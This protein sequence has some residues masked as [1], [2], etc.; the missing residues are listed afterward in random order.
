MGKTFYAKLAMGNMKK[1][2][3]LYTP[4]LLTGVCMVILFYNIAALALNMGLGSAILNLIMGLGAVVVGVFATVFLYYTNSFLMKRRQ[5][6]FGLF[7]ML[8]MEKRHLRKVISF[9][10]LYTAMISITAGLILGILTNKLMF[11]LL[12]RLLRFEVKMGFEVSL[13]AIAGTIV[14]FCGIFAL[15]LMSNVVKVSRA[16]P[17]ELLKGNQTGE[18][19]PK[20]RWVLTLVGVVTLGAG[21]A[22]ALIVKEPLDAILLFFVAVLLVITGTYCLFTAGNVAFFKALRKNKSYYYKTRH[23]ISVSGMIYRMKRNAVGLGNICI[24]SAAV[25]LMISTTVSLYIGIEDAVASTFPRDVWVGYHDSDDA[26]IRNKIRNEVQDV[27]DKRALTAVD[28]MDYNAYKAMS[29]EP[30][31][32]ISKPYFVTLSDYNKLSGKS[33]T[34]S[35]GEIILCGAGRDLLFEQLSLHGQDFIVKSTADA[36]KLFWAERSDGKSAYYVVVSDVSVIKKLIG[37]SEWICAWNYAFNLDAS[38]DDSIKIYDEINAR[39]YGIGSAQ[40]ASAF[41]NREAFFEFAGGLLFLGIFLGTMFIISMALVIYYKQISEGY[42]DKERFSIMQKVGLERTEVRGTIRSQVLMVFFL[43]LVTAIIHI[44]VAFPMITKLLAVLNLKNIPLFAVCTA[45]T[46]VLFSVIY[47]MVYA[48]T[49]REYY[50][51]VR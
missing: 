28:V 27:L 20:T 7:N 50:R 14:L 41:L 3:K 46:M 9:E 35:G 49:S 39:L 40:T 36:S 24:L 42:E 15:V 51:I 17:I 30:E 8:G 13:I 18:R 47:G 31:D 44:T 43:P 19:E 1:N 5:K 4:F 16:N 2:G 6:E 32:T 37:E 21:Y 11:L 38:G 23:F 29:S 45:V 25:L 22:I 34:L 48:L 33:E 12:L 26:D 10:T